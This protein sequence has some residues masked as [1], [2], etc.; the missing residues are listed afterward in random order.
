[1]LSKQRESSMSRCYTQLTGKE[2]LFLV[3]KYVLHRT[4]ILLSKIFKVEIF[5]H[6]KNGIETIFTQK[7]IVN[8]TN[9]YKEM[10]SSIESKIKF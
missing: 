9:N 6:R 8:F 2:G 4:N 5:I 3:H 7:L 1:M 10:A